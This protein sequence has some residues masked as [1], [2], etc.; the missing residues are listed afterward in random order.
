M[1]RRSFETLKRF[2]SRGGVSDEVANLFWLGMTLASGG[3]GWVDVTQS[4]G[5]CSGEAE[6][7]AEL[8]RGSHGELS[9]TGDASRKK[10][11]SRAS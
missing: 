9:E 6:G 1:P 4:Y 2:A 8:D 11:S 10:T 3:V 5:A 7:G